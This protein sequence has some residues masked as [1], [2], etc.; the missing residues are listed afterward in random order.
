[1]S[2]NGR[3]ADFIIIDDLS[4]SK[5]SPEQ[6]KKAHDWLVASLPIKTTQRKTL[7]SRMYAHFRA[8]YLR[9]KF[10]RQRNK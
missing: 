8:I 9:W 4:D 6:L 5:A 1:M 10:K 2:L 7:L 3:N